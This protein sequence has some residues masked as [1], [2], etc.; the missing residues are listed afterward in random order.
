MDTVTLRI[1][2][3]IATALIGIF[4]F[5]LAGSI[6]S[7]FAGFYGGLPFWLIVLFVMSFAVYDYVEEAFG[8]ND[9][10]KFILIMTLIIACGL[11]FIYGA[12]GAS[13]LFEVGKGVRVRSLGSSDNPYLVDGMWPKY[14]WYGAMVVFAAITL[15]VSR[16]VMK[17]Q[18]MKS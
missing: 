4:I 15:F 12:Y 10:V 14:F 11:A 9:R 2:G 18:A 6:S 7:G 17:K 13:T 8:I 1:V 16:R 3:L 5:A